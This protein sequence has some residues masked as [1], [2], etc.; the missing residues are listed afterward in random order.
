MA[1]DRISPPS[2]TVK[3]ASG[4]Q[5]DNHVTLTTPKQAPATEGKYWGPGKGS[6]D[7]IMGK[8]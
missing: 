7:K 8:A 5:D 3:G 4:F 2:K 6:D 1:S